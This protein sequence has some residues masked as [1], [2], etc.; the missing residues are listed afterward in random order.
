MDLYLNHKFEIFCVIN[1]LSNYSM[2]KNNT[3]GWKLFLKNNF[4]TFTLRKKKNSRLVFRQF[5][6][7]NLIRRP[8]SWK[9]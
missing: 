5:I 4:F 9:K 1:Y 8:I 2:V 7:N 6:T 3:G